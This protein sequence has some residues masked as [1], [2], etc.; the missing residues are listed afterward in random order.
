MT[1][2]T[3]PAAFDYLEAFSRN[4]GLVTEEEQRR[5]RDTRVCIAGL[6]GVGGAHALALA[7]LGVGRFSLADFDRFEIVNMNRQL[8]ATATSLGRPKVDVLAEMITAVNPDADL[9][10]F[11]EGLREDNAD[12]FLAGGDVAIDGI[13]FFGMP[14]RRLLF[15]AARERGVYAMTAAPVGFGA[16][17]HLFSPTGMTFEEYFDIR[18]GMG[19][20]EQLVQFGLGLAPRML[21]QGYFPPRALDLANGRTPSL[22]SACLLASVLVA[23]EVANLVLRRRP[24]RPAPYFLQFDPLAARY[25]TGWLWRGNRNPIQRAK[26][27]WVL[28]TNPQLRRLIEQ[29]RT[30]NATA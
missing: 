16:T 17:I 22:G 1:A 18:D 3:S 6:G 21:Q 4:L 15:R 13:D 24:A 14:A 11:P 23:T 28:R 7:R 19:P 12:V 2:P 26:R 27:W 10:L 30:A 25:A 5:L 9:R 29:T 20:A 8:G